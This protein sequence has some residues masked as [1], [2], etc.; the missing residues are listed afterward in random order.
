MGQSVNKITQGIDAVQE[1][2]T[3]AAARN[4]DKYLQNTQEA[5]SSGKMAASLRRVTLQDW[6]TAAKAKASRVGSG[7]TAAKD[8]MQRHLTAWLPHVAAVRAQVK[9]MA[10][11]TKEDRIAR[12]V[13]NA[14]LL[15]QFRRS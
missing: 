15:S 12:M 5:V 11:T 2:P 8:K 1:S 6:K 9:Q 10:S 14:R 4:L 7:A 3:E 13:E